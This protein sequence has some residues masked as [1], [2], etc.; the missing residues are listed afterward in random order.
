MI[1]SHAHR[2]VFVKT[3]KTAGTS[4]E[5]AL[6]EHAGPD[7]VLTSFALAEDNEARRARGSQAQN[8]VIPLHR[9][10]APEWIRLA[11]RLERSS[12]RSHMAASAIRRLMPNRQWNDYFTFTIA[13]N[14]WHTAA[15]AYAW[16]A[17]YSWHSRSGDKP[18]SFEEFLLTRQ[19]LWA[20]WPLYTI[21]DEVIVDHVIRFEDLE[22]GLA[23]VT[24]KLGLPSLDVPRAKSGIRTRDDRELFGTTE[25]EIVAETCAAEIE[26]FGWSY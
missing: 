6:S 19:S 24:D 22:T 13:R 8:Q 21:D 20:N 5:I 9:Y 15:S 3:R 23:G 12:Y 18:I 25:R 4:V 7:D 16:Q 11:R 2:Y 1:I 14:P 10:G 17:S 26:H